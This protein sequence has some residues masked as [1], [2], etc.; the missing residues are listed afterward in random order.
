VRRLGDRLPVNRARLFAPDGSCGIQ[1]KLAPTSREREACGLAP[2]GPLRLFETA[3]G[4]IGILIGD[5]CGLPLLARALTAAGADVLLAPRCA[6]TVRGYWRG[7]IAGMARAL[8]GQ[9]IVVH[10]TTVGPADWLPI[11]AQSH[12]AAAIYV[13]PEAAFP[14]DGVLAAGK[15]DVAGW[16]HGEVA[17]DA[18]RQGRNSSDWEEQ[19][20]IGEVE[21]VTLGVSAEA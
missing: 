6:E 19:S 12:G 9:C 21:T 10:A 11:A 3:L 4:R 15:A 1:D 17:L 8:E 14:E 16:V 18:L 5:D 20:R 13:P 2:G 7:R